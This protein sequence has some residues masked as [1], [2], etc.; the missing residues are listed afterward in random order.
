MIKAVLFDI[1]GVLI[2]SLEANFQ[3]YRRLLIKTGY[4]PPTLQE[5]LPFM[6][7]T[8]EGVV[9]N[10]THASDKEIQRMVGMGSEFSEELYPSDLLKTPP[11]VESTIQKLYEDYHLGIVT[12]RVREHIYSM[13]PLTNLEK[14][15]QVSVGFGDTMRH[16]P[17]PEPLLFAC[18]NL[19]I[20]PEET[21]YVGDAESDFL[22]TKAARMKFI[23][24][25]ENNFMS[26]ENYTNSFEK[27]S[28]IITKL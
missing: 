28:D 14:Y 23:L 12:S 4:M 11:Y 2:D 3:F 26:V 19:K 15:F 22:A 27:F 10:I 16:K 17:D 9:R 1:D 13:P 21:V 8:M 18:K 24:F 25:G 7:N 5:Y 6:H 20:K